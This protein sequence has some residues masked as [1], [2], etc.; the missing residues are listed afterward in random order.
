LRLGLEEIAAIVLDHDTAAPVDPDSDPVAGEGVTPEA[1]DAA[2]Q[3]AQTPE[4]TT[5][6]G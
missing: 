2:E 1:V 6:E 3:A 4:D 5:N